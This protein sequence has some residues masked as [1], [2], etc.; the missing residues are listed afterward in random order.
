MIKILLC[1]ILGHK[2]MRKVVSGKCTKYFLGDPY[3]VT[4]YK[5]EQMAFCMR[6]GQPNLH[7]DDRKWEKLFK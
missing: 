4:A 3:D 7:Y 2:F 1:W 6:C 5:W